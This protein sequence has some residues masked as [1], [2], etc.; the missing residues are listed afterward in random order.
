MNFKK[1]SK[2]ELVN[3]SER[4]D[5]E[6]M[7]I[8]FGGESFVIAT[9]PPEFTVKTGRRKKYSEHY[10]KRVVLMRNR[11]DWVESDVE[12]KP[13]NDNGM[14]LIRF[15]E[16]EAVDDVFD[17]KIGNIYYRVFINKTLNRA[18]CNE[19]I[20]YDKKDFA[21]LKNP[22]NKE[23]SEKLEKTFIEGNLLKNERLDT[24]AH[25]KQRVEKFYRREEQK[26]QSKKNAVGNRRKIYLIKATLWCIKNQP[27]KL[28][29]RKPILLR[30][31]KKF[32]RSALEEESN[33]T[34]DSFV[35]M[36]RRIWDSLKREYNKQP[37][38]FRSQ[39]S[40]Q[41]YAKSELKI[42]RNIAKQ[43]VKEDEKGFN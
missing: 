10:P 35:K 26:E 3:E 43:K 39:K 18:W 1:D 38:E 30:A 27:K 41:I 21:W 29:D 14:S 15:P 6:F 9:R 22:I 37:R 32:K 34:E 23:M 40:L 13:E 36:V 25:F 42:S 24:I 5:S 7:N 4:A 2:K 28:E 20:F 11:R 17:V 16:P 12:D 19:V 8:K 31:Y 33:V